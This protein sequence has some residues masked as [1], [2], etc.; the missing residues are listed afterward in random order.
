VATV[1]DRLRSAEVVAS[2]FEQ[3]ALWTYRLI[4]L[5]LIAT[6]I[7]LPLTSFSISP[8]AAVA[9]P[10]W[11]FLLCGAAMLPRRYGYARFSGAMEAVALVYGQGFAILFLL[12]PLTA[13]SGP[14]ADA[15]LA[16]I[17]QALGFDWPAFAS[18][19][20]GHALAQHAL[21][22]AYHS[23][24][25]QPLVIILALFA[26]GREDRAWRFVTA[27]TIAALVTALLYPFAPA[28]G[29]FFHYHV[30]ASD[31]PQIQSGWQF[32]PIV[33]AVKS[34]AR[35]IAPDTFTGMVSF[36]SYHAAAGAI[37]AWAL[38]PFRVRWPF[39]ALNVAM[40]AAALICGAHYLVDVLAGI[41]IGGGSIF[42]SDRALRCE[43]RSS[44]D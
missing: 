29:A 28:V 19:F 9:L 30:V 37:F 40:C 3:R 11:A 18:L 10:L 24:N 33:E 44:H 32:G 21:V 20:A 4:G 16:A 14:L 15:H 2:P 42:L 31:F 27:G 6:A 39:V 17:D 35:N 25:W 38:W 36:P 8:A 12:F 22:I 23:F 34:G 7:L 26:T 1:L 5:E 41:A 43:R 13:L